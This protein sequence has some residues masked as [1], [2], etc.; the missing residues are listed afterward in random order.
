MLFS[1]KICR[2]ATPLA[3]LAGIVGLALLST[4]YV[5]AR[6]LLG[7]SL[8]GSMMAFVGWY[9][10]GERAPRILAILAGAA[11]VQVATLMSILKAL[12]GDRN[13]AWEPTRREMKVAH[14]E[15]A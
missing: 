3:G 9:W 5:W 6:W 14:P 4:D 13:A 11:S 7:V 2:W 12:Q 1:H 8:A 10:P 15:S